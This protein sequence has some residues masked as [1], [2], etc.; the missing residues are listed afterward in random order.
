LEA[1]A[2]APGPGSP[3]E[4]INGPRSAESSATPTPFAAS[5]S[6]VG[7]GRATPDDES[8]AWLESLATDPRG[9]AHVRLRALLLRATQFEVARRQDQL[10]HVDDRE[11]KKLAHT[12]ADTAL[13]RVVASL[14]HY[15]GG[16]P[17]ATWA[18]KFALLEAATRLRKLGWH[19]GHPPSWRQAREGG[20]SP[21][22]QAALSDMTDALTADQCYVFEA[23]TVD[24]VPI[25]VLAEDLGT[26]RGDVYQTLQSA[27]AMLRARL[28][29]ADSV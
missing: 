11:L 5:A 17:F 8:R 20:L 27:R 19:D 23:L 3:A 12:A 13:T 7:G 1:T 2:S 25:D 6:A 16:S 10:L 18:A 29:Q 4:A 21:A 26:T 22:V 15:R 14:D 24:G 9:E 28:V